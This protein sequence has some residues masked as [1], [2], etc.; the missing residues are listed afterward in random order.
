MNRSIHQAWVSQ[1]Y[2]KGRYGYP[3]GPTQDDGS[4]GYTQ[5]FQGG[6]IHVNSAGNIIG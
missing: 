6:S 2:E 1:G 3:V 5:S 4:G